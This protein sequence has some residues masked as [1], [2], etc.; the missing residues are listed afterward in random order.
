LADPIGPSVSVN[1][2]VSVSVSV[3]VPKASGDGDVNPS[4]EQALSAVNDEYQFAPEDFFETDDGDMIDAWIHGLS[5]P[6]NQ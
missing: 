2:S 5:D 1:V 3:A 6:W 4:D